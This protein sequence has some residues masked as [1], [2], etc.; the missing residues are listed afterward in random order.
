MINTV[1]IFIALLYR[2]YCHRKHQKDQNHKTLVFLIGPPGVG[3][4]TFA[5]EDFA[6]ADIFERDQWYAYYRKTAESNVRSAKMKTHD[7]LVALLG[8][9]NH[10]VVDSVNASENGRKYYINVMKPTRVISYNFRVRANS[11]AEQ[12]D[13]LAN[14][15]KDRE[16]STFPREEDKQRSLIDM[17]LPQIEYDPNG[18]D[19]WVDENGM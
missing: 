7:H 15:V 13:F 9:S 17:I 6:S 8:S 5:R 10:V 11:Y 14:R 4:T 18:I 19:L 12:V 16:H 1:L 3:K 2:R